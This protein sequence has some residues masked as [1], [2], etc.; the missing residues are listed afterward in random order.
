MFGLS[1]LFI[2]TT[3]VF[4]GL[5][6]TEVRQKEKS[7]DKEVVEKD[8]DLDEPDADKPKDD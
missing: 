8:Q 3:L 6:L 5:E 4:R 7:A 2:G 1:L